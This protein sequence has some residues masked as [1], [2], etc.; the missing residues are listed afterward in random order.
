MGVACQRGAHTYHIVA[1]RPNFSP[2]LFEA[3]TPERGESLARWEI[4]ALGACVTG[5]S[6]GEA[7]QAR[8][9]QSVIGSYSRR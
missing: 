8:R 5:P 7:Q 3:R 4:S 6:A 9:L 1:T 2:L